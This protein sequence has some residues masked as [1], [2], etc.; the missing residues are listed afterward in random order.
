MNVPS[1]TTATKRCSVTK[2]KRIKITNMKVIEY[3]D[4][5]TDWEESGWIYHES[6]KLVSFYPASVYY[7]IIIIALSNLVIHPAYK[8]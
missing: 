3:F 7:K 8:S 4:E 5:G 6:L 2:I 1:F